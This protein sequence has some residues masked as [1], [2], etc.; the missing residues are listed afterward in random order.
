NGRAHTLYV[1]PTRAG[2]Y[3]WIF[4]GSMGSCRKVRLRPHLL[5]V[6]WIVGG[7]RPFYAK[8]IAGDTVARAARTLWLE[9]EDGSR[10]Q[11]PFVWVSKPIDA[12][13]F[14]VGIPAGH[15]AKG[16]RLHAVSVRSPTGRVLARHFFAYERLVVATP[17]RRPPAR[18]P[19]P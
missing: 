9:Y 17:R 1:A 3:C 2:G 13:F 4:S 7:G 8:E 18:Q 16:T 10:T 6:G 15:H 11:I 12:G 14:M 19:Q 5:S